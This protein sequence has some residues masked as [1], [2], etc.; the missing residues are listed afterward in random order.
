MNYAVSYFEG[1]CLQIRHRN[2]F[3]GL[4]F[5][6]HWIWVSPNSTTQRR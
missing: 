6:K 2:Q 5:S 1:E 4:S 3:R